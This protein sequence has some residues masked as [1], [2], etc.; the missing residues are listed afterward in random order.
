MRRLW[1]E[2]GQYDALRNS[3]VASEVFDIVVPDR[4][5]FEEAITKADLCRCPMAGTVIGMLCDV[6]SFFFF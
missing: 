6:V 4:P 1:V 3:D 5:G 2:R